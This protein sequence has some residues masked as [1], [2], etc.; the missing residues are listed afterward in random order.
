MSRRIVVG[1]SG[2]VSSAWCLGWA[3]RTYPAIEVDALWHDTKAEHPDTVRFIYE[4]AH[5]LRVPVI[6]RSDGRSV[7]EVE[8]DNGALANN[9]MAFC[10]RILKAEQKERYFKE[11][12]ASGVTEIIS[13]LGFSAIEWQRIQRA[14]M[15]AELGGYTVR[16]PIAEEGI[17]KQQCADWCIS[18]GVPPSEMYRWSE[19]ANCV[20][21][22]RGGKA[23][24]LKVK[25]N[26]PEAFQRAV[27]REAEFGHTFLKDTTLIQLSKT[28]LKR[29]V[30]QRESIDIGACECGS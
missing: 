4:L 25:E 18:I 13:V 26:E 15:N 5:K 14:T 6:E 29:E 2:G 19:H 30:K 9:R 1:H 21:C 20:G 7:E 8:D 3:L 23:Y 16:F 24:W 11:L 17:T 27:D 22:R 12:R 10:S 28:G